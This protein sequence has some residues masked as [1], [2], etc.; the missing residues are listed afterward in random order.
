VRRPCQAHRKG[1][2][3]FLATGEGPILNQR[4]ELT[5]Q[6]RDGHEFP[7]ELTIWPTVFGRT[8]R[9]NA[10][11]QDI[12][13]RKQAE[14][15]FRAQYAT[16]KVLAEATTVGEAAPMILKA[17]C[18]NLE[19]SVGALWI[20]DEPGRELRCA[21]VW[22]SPSAIVPEFEAVSRRI[23]FGKGIGIPGRAWS[24]AEPVWVS[25]LASD[26]NFPRAPHAA[27][28]GLHAGFGCPVLVE[29]EVIA[30]LEFY[31]TKVLEPDHDLLGMMATI[32]TQLGQFISRKRNEEGFVRLSHQHEL[33]LNTAGDGIYGLD[34]QGR[35]TFV[36]A[37]AAQMTGY[38]VEELLGKNQHEVLH[39]S[40]PDGTPYPIEQC[41]IIAVLKDGQRRQ[42]KNEVFW[43]KDGTSFPVEY[44]ATPIKENG[45]LLG[46]VVMFRDVTERKRL[47]E[48]F[49]QAQK[50]EA[51]G[52]L[53]GG[54]AHDFNN[55]LT[56]I[57]G[58]SDIVSTKLVPTDPARE[59][60]KEIGKAGERA[61]GLTRQL[62]AF[63]R[64]QVLEPRVL[65]LNEVVRG[66][67]KMLQRLIGEDLDVKTVLAH[68]LGNV[69]VD[70]G[71]VEQVLTNLAVNARDAMPQQG[72]L[73]IETG[74]AELDESYAQ[75]HPEVRPGRY[76]LLAVSDT[77][78]GMTEEVK[79]RIF[80]PFFTTKEVGKGTGLGLA[81]VFGIVKQSEGII[82][83]YSEVGRGT[84]FKI[85]LPRVEEKPL[86]TS[87]SSPGLRTT[88][89][90][91]ETILLVEDEKAV[92][93][94]T[95][96]ALEQAGYTVLEAAHGLDALRLCEAHAG[97]IHLL[98]SDVVMPQLGGRELAERLTTLRPQMRVLFLSGYTPDA[99]VRHGVIEADVAFLQK[100]FTLDAL[101]RKVREVL[102]KAT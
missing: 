96:F 90:G 8:P 36:N 20:P 86:R 57:N 61:A 52:R 77:G 41:P 44:T 43:R 78:H 29:S 73:T 5:A 97:P 22:H 15:R 7:V 100:P 80:E 33:I 58:Y 14:R 89:R 31:N 23:A 74:N 60:V 37:A 91:S 17:I 59:L 45:E 69:K 11:I 87:K 76:V 66:V 13:A 47:E 38:A 70:P 83:V 16:T 12:T 25:D 18:E 101:T 34:R 4:I 84:T 26:G 27:K 95:R 49:R 6:H 98:V 99:V 50:M 46:A 85:Y 62:L 51:V 79:R 48:Q 75:T 68:D 92:R 42:G 94:L 71:Q 3:H 67:T 40:K 93:A 2:V 1:L 65:D 39:H 55:L 81:T 30:V 21:E 88:P 32:G 53:A 72:Q 24:G 9:F 28:E 102:D 63:S 19:W 64:Q 56:I 35:T 82:E 54:V 10:F